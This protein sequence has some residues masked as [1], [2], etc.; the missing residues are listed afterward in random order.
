MRAATLGSL[1]IVLAAALLAPAAA[2]ARVMEEK[3][4]SA[5]YPLEPGGRVQVA[6]VQGSITVEGWDRAEVEVTAVQRAGAMEGSE[7]AVGVERGPDWI[8]LRTLYPA[9][10]TNPVQLDYYLRVPRQVQL[11]ELLTVNGQVRV[12]DIEGRVAAR[13]L[14]GDI[15]QERIS[16]RVTAR[17][18][19]GSIR[20][21]LRA[22]PGGNA[23]LSLETVNGD[24]LVLLPPR[25]NADLELSTVAG[26]IE[27]P[28]VER[29]AEAGDNVRRTRLGR[30]GPT[31]KLRTVRGNI[32]IGQNVDVY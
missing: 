9:D 30:G 20:L 14:N 25:A 13:T 27:N 12:R 31:L 2:E 16:G 3:I 22:L 1:A 10:G 15:E 29:A 7:P 4:W 26:R 23:E 24:L 17:A 11:D 5:S 21:A 6:N 19:N 28:L 8:S 32:R 18:L